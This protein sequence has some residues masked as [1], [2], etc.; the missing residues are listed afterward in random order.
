MCIYG[1]IDEQ[2]QMIVGR[3]PEKAD[4]VIPVA[5]G[6]PRSILH[7]CPVTPFPSSLACIPIH[8]SSSMQH[9]A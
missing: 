6:I 3:V 5:T 9:N 8:M 4:L 7:P 2:E 1:V